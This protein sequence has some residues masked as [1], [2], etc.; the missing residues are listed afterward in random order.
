MTKTN[1][2]GALKSLRRSLRHMKSLLAWANLVESQRKPDTPPAFRIDRG[3]ERDIKAE[4]GFFLNTAMELQR[5]FKNGT[6][7]GTE[8]QRRRWRDYLGK[9]WKHYQKM[10]IPT[11]L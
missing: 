8:N 5:R 2:P 10:D 11:D 4:Q 9:L 6:I 1:I 3:L 7:D